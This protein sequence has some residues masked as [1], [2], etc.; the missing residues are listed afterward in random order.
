LRA[1]LIPLTLHSSIHNNQ[2][3]KKSAVSAAYRNAFTNLAV[4]RLAN[5]KMEVRDLGE[6]ASNLM[7]KQ[8]REAE[9]VAA[10]VAAIAATAAAISAGAA[11]I[12]ATSS[13]NTN[14]A[15]N[16]TTTTTTTPSTQTPP[17]QTPPAPIP[18]HPDLILKL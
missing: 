12:A 6:A 15:N 3:A 8:E 5:G 16:T 2:S 10:E 11:V 1:L 17:T 4:I 7:A 13:T 14:I 18:P 9:A